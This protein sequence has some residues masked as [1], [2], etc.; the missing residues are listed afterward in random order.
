MSAEITPVFTLVVG[1]LLTAPAFATAQDDSR[2]FFSEWELTGH[3]GVEGRAFSSGAGH[4]GQHG[5][6]RDGPGAS[7]SLE[8]EP[9][10]QPTPWRLRRPPSPHWHSTLYKRG[11]T[12]KRWYTKHTHCK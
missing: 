2:R 1:A 11:L 5:G 12:Q 4:D 10:S 7:F 3:T 9:A 8:P 6:Q